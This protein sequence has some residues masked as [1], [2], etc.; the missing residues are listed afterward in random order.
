M[1]HTQ[2]STGT[3]RTREYRGG[4]LYRTLEDAGVQVN[5]SSNRRHSDPDQRYRRAYKS[6]YKL[7]EAY[8]RH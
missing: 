4:G 3:Y 2:R 1:Y 6:V 7:V 5:Q 8:N